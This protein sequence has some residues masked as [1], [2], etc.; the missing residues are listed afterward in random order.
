[1]SSQ[2]TVKLEDLLEWLECPYRNRNR[3][4]VVDVRHQGILFD[5]LVEQAISRTVVFYL[6][7]KLE[8]E[9]AS[10][11]RLKRE[12]SKAWN[13][14]KKSLGITDIVG[15]LSQVLSQVM[16]LPAVLRGSVRLVEYWEDEPID[17]DGV[18]VSVGPSLVFH[19]KC[20]A[21]QHVFVYPYPNRKDSSL[22]RIVLSSVAASLLEHSEYPLYYG[23]WNGRELEV[24]KPP[25]VEETSFMLCEAV[26]LYRSGSELP[27][28]HASTCQKCVFREVCIWR[29]ES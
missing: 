20:G 17:V 29:Q 12:F 11:G 15:D 6:R 23:Y 16:S 7:A 28:P 9:D 13:Y 4:A 2:V 25:Q 24:Y 8:E 1:M 3:D 19:R 27:L 26:R 10:L 18:V 5:R 21:H 22:P 14:T